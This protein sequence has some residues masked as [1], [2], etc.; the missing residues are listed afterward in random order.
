LKI[1]HYAEE[2][3]DFTYKLPGW[4]ER[5]LVMQRNWIGKSVGAEVDFK[6]DGRDESIKI[7]TTRPDTLY[8]V[9]FMSIAAGH[10]AIERITT[11]ERKAEVDSFVKRFK[12]ESKPRDM[13]EIKKEGVFTGAY[14]LNPL[15]G[16]R[17]PVYV[18]NFV[19]MGYGTGAVMAFRGSLSIGALVS[20]NA[21]FASII[22]FSAVPPI[23]T[24]TIR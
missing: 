1:T 18:A 23:P 7:F 10:P 19:L 20:F 24:P 17:V 2:L 3:L 11:D 15:T 8:G 14:C 12:A 6:I 16:D 13:E 9:T 21:L 22:V 5:V 4:P